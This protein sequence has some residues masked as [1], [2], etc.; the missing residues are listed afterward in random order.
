V[1]LFSKYSKRSKKLL[2]KDRQGRRGRGVAL[3]ISDHLKYMELHLGINE[4]LT[5]SLW[6][7]TSCL[8][9]KIKWMRTS[10]NR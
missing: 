8:I 5:G 6:S 7:A 9:R 1:S 3:C 2:R 10:I 4:E